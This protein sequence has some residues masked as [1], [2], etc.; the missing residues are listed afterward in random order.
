MD[1][2]MLFVVVLNLYANNM[3]PT[4]RSLSSTSWDY[5]VREKYLGSRTLLLSRRY[6]KS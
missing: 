4:M 1:Y 6:D 5:H 3:Y 2:L